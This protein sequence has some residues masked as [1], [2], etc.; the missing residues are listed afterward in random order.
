MSRS[1]ERRWERAQDYLLQQQFA[2]AQVQLESLRA[3]SPQDMRTHLLSAQLAW[4]QGSPRDAAASALKAAHGVDC[5]PQKLGILIDLLLRV[6]ESAVGHDLLGR[7]VWRQVDDVNTLLRYADLCQRFGEHAESLAAFD[8]LLKVRPDDGV[9]H[10]H[11]GQQLEFLGRLQEAESAYEACLERAPG[12]AHAAYCLARLRRQSPDEHRLD[13]IEAGLKHV[14]SGSREHADFEFARYHVLEDRGQTDAAWHALANANALMHA[15]AA[16]DAALEQQGMQDF[17]EKAQGR[18][19]R[20]AEPEGDGPCPIF[21]L[22]L[23]RSGTTVLERMLANHSQVASAGELMDFGRQLLRAGNNSLAA[24]ANLF[25][26]QLTLD[27]AEVGRGYRAQTGWRARG[28]THFIDKQP[29]NY[30]VAGLIHAALPEAKILHLVRDPMDACF[31]IWRARFGNAYAWSY[32]FK[33]LAAHHA[34]YRQ[35]M[36]HWHAAYPDAILDV[37]Y[38]DLVHDPA[39][40]LRQVMDFCGLVPEVGCEDLVRNTTPVSTLSSSQ[41]REPIHSRALGQWRRYA[42]QLEPLR[43]NLLSAA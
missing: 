8:R 29:G 16:T 39:A 20:I 36:Q 26:D 28:K 17:L 13:M 30:M 2:A 15:Q 33:T 14:R 35:L 5:E 42:E 38:A 40:T 6:G 37:A 23:P 4:H 18:R 9:L 41:V 22:G 43:R 7:P 11:R 31:S 34:L 24:G 21:I 19:L 25:A 27:F 3:M 12:Y 1:V 10:C 32:D